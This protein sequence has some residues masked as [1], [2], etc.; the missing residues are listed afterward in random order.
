[1]LEPLRRWFESR[2]GSTSPFGKLDDWMDGFR[3]E[4]SVKEAFA[5]KAAQLSPPRGSAELLREIMRVVAF[6]P[7]EVKKVHCADVDAVARML[8]GKSNGPGL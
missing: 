1:M 4:R 3:V 5:R 6:G 2:G 8:G 7:E